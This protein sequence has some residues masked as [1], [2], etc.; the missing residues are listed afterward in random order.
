MP[1]PLKPVAHLLIAIGALAACLAASAP[2]SARVPQGFIGMV[3]A[4]PVFPTGPNVN[5]GRQLDAMTAS[6]VESILFAVDWADV[7]RMRD[8]SDIPASE[9]SQFTDVDG[10]PLRLGPTG[11]G[12]PAGRR[13]RPGDPPPRAQRAGLGRAA[14]ER[15]RRRHAP[16]ASPRTPPSSPR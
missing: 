10:L 11:Q 12:R 6:G 3:L 4:D 16:L 15:R 7:S 9:V 14:V 2:A 8:W 13:P 1:G 5:L